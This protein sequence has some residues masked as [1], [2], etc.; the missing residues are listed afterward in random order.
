[1]NR[2]CSNERQGG[3]KRKMK[4]KIKG[5]EVIDYQP[6]YKGA[7]TTFKFPIQSVECIQVALQD[8]PK[9]TSDSSGEKVTAV[10]K[11]EELRAEKSEDKGRKR[12]LN[13]RWRK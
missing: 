3:V 1:M 2:F 8:D 9:K 13:K 10:K 11:Q 4:A 5:L 12:S 7:F 6:M